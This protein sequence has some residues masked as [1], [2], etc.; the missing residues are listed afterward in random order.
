MRHPRDRGPVID[1]LPAAN[2]EANVDGDCLSAINFFAANSVQFLASNPSLADPSLRQAPLLGQAQPQPAG[3]ARQ[4]R[5]TGSIQNINAKIT[6]NVA[7]TVRRHNQNQALGR[8]I[9]VD[10]PVRFV[11]SR[12]IN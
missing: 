5:R 12:L 6:G 4:L 8:L 3:L 7:L 2:D 1:D 10:L 9:V 11:P